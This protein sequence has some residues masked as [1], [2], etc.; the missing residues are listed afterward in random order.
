MKGC[1]ECN[2]FVKPWFGRP[3]PLHNQSLATWNG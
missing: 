2:T 3:D 1:A